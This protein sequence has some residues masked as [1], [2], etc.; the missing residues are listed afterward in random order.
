MLGF[1][2][3]R[4]QAL[5]GLDDTKVIGVARKWPSGVH[6]RMNDE[7]SDPN[8][9]QNPPPAVDVRVCDY[10]ANKLA[11]AEIFPACELD[12]PQAKRDAAIASDK[13]LLKQ[14]GAAFGSHSTPLARIAANRAPFGSAQPWFDKLDHPATSQEVALGRAIFS[15]DGTTRVCPMPDS[16]LYAER[17]LSPQDP[18]SWSDGT[19]YTTDGYVWQA[20]EVMVNGKWERYYGFTGRHQIEKVPASEIKFPAGAPWTW[21]PVTEPF[22]ATID[23]PEQNQWRSTAYS[24][25]AVA[26]DMPLVVMV[27]THNNSGLDQQIPAAFSVPDGAARILPP[28]ITLHLTYSDKIDPVVANPPSQ[29]EPSFGLFGGGR[30]PFDYGSWTEVPLKKGITVG[31]GKAPGPI[32]AAGSDLTLLQIDLRDFFDM[33]KPGTYRF[34]ATFQVPGEKPPDSKEEYRPS[35]SIMFTVLDKTK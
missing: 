8:P 33:S 17:P 32:L 29:P 23:V 16:P 1:A 9:P 6:T 10:Y 12:S 30:T 14:Y 24:G 28:G 15:L 27:K 26:V 19:H 25:Y 4:E 18:T 2:S 5:A 3:F 13:A 34:A 21:A 20:E 22:D 7:G 31:D 35:G 11:G